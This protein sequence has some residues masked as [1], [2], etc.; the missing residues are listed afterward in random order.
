MVGVHAAV[1][2]APRQPPAASRAAESLRRHSLRGPQRRGKFHT[3]PPHRKSRLRGVC[4][5][6]GWGWSGG[7]GRQSGTGGHHSWHL[8]LP[9]DNN[10][11]NILTTGWRYSVAGG[12]DC[13]RAAA[14]A[15]AEHLVR[16]S[17]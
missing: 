1:A 8:T 3:V 2:P 13:F 16:P 9:S 12:T 5:A 6:C 11:G 17:S 15:A 10:D 7:A 4:N 14:H